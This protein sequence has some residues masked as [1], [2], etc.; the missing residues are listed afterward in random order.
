LNQ[1]VL[2]IF[3]PK[4]RIQASSIRIFAFWI[5][6]PAILMLTIAIIF[7]KNLILLETFKYKFELNLIH[8]DSS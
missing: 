4:E 3:F 8:L 5:S 1:N 7:L 2:Q 6:I